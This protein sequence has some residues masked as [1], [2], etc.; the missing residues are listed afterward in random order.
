MSK[1][2]RNIPAFFLW[3]AWSV[4]TAHLIIPHDHHMADS[5]SGRDERCPSSD[6]NAR[7]H[8]FPVHCHAFNELASEKATKYILTRNIQKDDIS[9]AFVKDFFINKFLTSSI[10]VSEFTETFPDCFPPNLSQLR[11]P[12]ILI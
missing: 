11:A 8:G 6:R 12:P 1:T 10:A 2:I 4:M 5:F 3:I 7:H 9:F